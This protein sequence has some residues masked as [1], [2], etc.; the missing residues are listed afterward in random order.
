MSLLIFISCSSLGGLSGQPADPQ[1]STEIII[2]VPKGATARGMGAHLENAGVLDDGEAFSWFVRIH[3]Q[4][5]C[6]KAGKH[7]VTRAMTHENIIASMC[8]VPLVDAEPFTVLEGWRIREIDAALVKAGHIKP[9]EYKLLAQSPATFKASF[10]LP[11]SS[12]EGYLFP[13]TYMVEPGNFDTRKFI[14]RQIDMFGTRF[15]SKHPEGFKGRSLSEIVIMASMIVREEPTERQ[16]PMVA[17]ILW[18]RIDNKWHLGGD[19]TSRYTLPKWNDRRAFLGKL[20]DPK[21]PY[22][23][24]LKPGLPPTAIGNPDLSS[25]ESAAAPVSSPYWYYLHDAKG[26]LHPS[27][28]VTEHEAYRRKYNVY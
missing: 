24:R 28:S 22:N 5:G 15:V 26:V 4:G 1:D 21:D 3:K 25:L 17:G 7:A 23:T 12:L 16:R 14:Q 10:P 2:E 6:I 11:S 18:K 9:G 19:A 20:R 27:R 8:G 13:E